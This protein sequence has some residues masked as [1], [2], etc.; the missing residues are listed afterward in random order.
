MPASPQVYLLVDPAEEDAL[1]AAGVPGTLGTTL[2]LAH[3]I[4][5][6]IQDKTFVPDA[7]TL[8]ATDPLWDTVKWGGLGNLCSLMYMCRIRI[9]L[10]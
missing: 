8:D 10:N 2:D 1:A 9:R 4:P 3:M 7:T 6:V 5:L